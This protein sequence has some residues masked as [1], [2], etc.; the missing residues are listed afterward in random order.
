MTPQ[1]IA[2]LL[3]LLLLLKPAAAPAQEIPPWLPR[4][5]LEIRIDV[6]NHVV[7]TQQRVTWTN[8]HHRAADTL[9]FNGHA[10]YK[11]PA[12]DIGFF[13]K[14]LELLRMNPKEALDIQGEALQVTCA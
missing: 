4:Y 7:L 14:T 8:R 6:D 12:S 3:A 9:V 2:L 13:A 5:D 11:V 1:R 10:H